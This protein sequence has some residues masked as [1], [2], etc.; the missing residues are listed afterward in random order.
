MFCWLWTGH[1]ATGIYALKNVYMNFYILP[2][3]VALFGNL[4][5]IFI[6]RRAGIRTDYLYSLVVIFA[7]HNVCELLLFLNFSQPNGLTVHFL[8]VY[9]AITFV[10]IATAC[11]LAFKVAEITKNDFLNIVE[12]LIWVGAG[13]GLFLSLFT[14]EI[15][16][17]VRDLSYSSTA[18][19]GD[20]YWLFQLTS[21][22]TAIGSAAALF[23]GQL[24]AT[25]SRQKTRC[26]FMLSAYIP[27]VV[28]ALSVLF[29]MNMGLQINATGILPITISLFIW[30]LVYSER[31]HRLTD[32]RRVV[33]GTRENKV[34]QQLQEV[35][36]KYAAGDMGYQD[37]SNEIELLL[38]AYSYDKHSGNVLQTAK[39]MKVGRSTLYKKMQKH[40][41]GRPYENKNNEESVQSSLKH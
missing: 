6:A 36:T 18:I 9:Y 27:L 7:T 20:S 17:G 41:M 4:V 3:L 10:L 11:S 2:A 1:W 26:L 24:V 23:K 34:A 25:D 35:F 38:L 33:P 37:A 5:V 22:V 40:S 16:S 8:S 31:R 21:A 13:I 30:I 29:M 12:K 19:K 28:G 15:V 32:I 14:E 39:F